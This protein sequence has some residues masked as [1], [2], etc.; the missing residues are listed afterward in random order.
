MIDKVVAPSENG[1]KLGTISIHFCDRRYESEK[2]IE[3]VGWFKEGRR[4][5]TDV[6]YRLSWIVYELM[7]SSATYETTVDQCYDASFV[8]EVANEGPTERIL[9]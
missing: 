6:R 3:C 7:S 5:V 1:R 2:S 4:G 8:E 9:S